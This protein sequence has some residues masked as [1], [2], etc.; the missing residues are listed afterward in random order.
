MQRDPRELDWRKFQ[1]HEYVAP[2]P[3]LAPFV[4]RYWLVEWTYTR[5]YRQ[6]IVPYPNVHLTLHGDSARLTGVSSGH[7]YQVL[8][9]AGRVFGIA[10]RPGMFRSFLGRAVSTITDREFPAAE[11]F[12]GVPAKHAVSEVE[13][14]LRARLPEPDPKAE[15]AARVVDRITTAPEIVRV[16]ALADEFGTTVRQLQRLFAEHV[17]VG[18]KW[19]IRRYRLHEVGERLASGVEFDWAGLAGELGYADQAHFVR[20]FTAMVGESPTRYAERYPHR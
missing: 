12:G 4:A 9:G 1:R 8:D 15:L 6:L 20:D 13:D 17:G 14:F 5:P 2:A 10:F 19:V 16:D 3:D 18:P 7:V 11:V